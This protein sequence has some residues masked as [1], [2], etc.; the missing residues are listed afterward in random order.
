MIWWCMRYAHRYA[1]R[2][3]DLAVLAELP[4]GDSEAPDALVVGALRESVGPGLFQ[5][6]M[7][8]LVLTD[9]RWGESKS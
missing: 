7:A 5:G 6:L 8:V 3:R 1:E 4:L 2:A 9:D